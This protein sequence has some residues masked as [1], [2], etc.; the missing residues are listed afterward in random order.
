MKF[1]ESV[2]LGT[3]EL[4]DPSAGHPMIRNTT[5]GSRARVALAPFRM[6]CCY[7]IL[8]KMWIV[9]TRAVTGRFQSAVD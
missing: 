5:L 4:S 9:L 7:G 3:V 8:V 2:R 1:F 6:G